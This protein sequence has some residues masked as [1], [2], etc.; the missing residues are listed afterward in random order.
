[1]W[2]G[3]APVAAVLLLPRV[4]RCVQAQHA[5]KV[6][7]VLL[8]REARRLHATRRIRCGV[9][10][11]AAVLQLRVARRRV[12]AG[13]CAAAAGGGGGGVVMMMMDDLQ[14]VMLLP[15]VTILL[16]IIVDAAADHRGCCC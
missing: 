9:A 11:T 4:V 3:W 12:H 5:V 8:K 15:I 6:C 14:T 2:R 13:N 1:M 10:G 16:L 7:E